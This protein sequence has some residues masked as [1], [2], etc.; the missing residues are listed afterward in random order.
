MRR[1]LVVI[2]IAIAALAGALA[3]AAPS[4][5]PT[6]AATPPPFLDDFSNP[7]AFAANWQISDYTNNPGSNGGTEFQPGN[8]RLRQD[9]R[10]ARR[11]RGPGGRARTVRGEE[12]QKG[13]QRCTLVA[14]Y[15]ADR[16][17]GQELQSNWVWQK[18][19]TQLARAGA[20]FPGSATL[21]SPIARSPIANRPV[22]FTRNL[23]FRGLL[24]QVSGSH[25][26][27]PR[28]LRDP[29]TDQ[30]ARRPPNGALGEWRPRSSPRNA[31]NNSYANA[32]VGGGEV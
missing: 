22:L 12:P 6:P 5:T 1:G 25:H 27:G 13:T 30:G 21:R 23:L 17:P 29:S 8:A 14:Q 15:Q 26:G 10:G 20:L 28:V 31:D 9:A 3:A 7:A 2:A 24:L 18:R 19:L 16:P 32:G 4:A 11:P